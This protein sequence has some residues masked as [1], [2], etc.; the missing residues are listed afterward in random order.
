MNSN[1]AILTTVLNWELYQKSSQLFP[2]NIQKYIIDGTN[3][4]YGLDS[5]IYM[6]KMLKGR[7]ID[8]LIMADEDVLF[9][10]TQGIFS[11]I[12]EMKL[13][14]Y[15]ISGVRDGGIIKNR[16]KNPYVINTFFSIINFKELELIWNEREVLKNNYILPDEFDDDINNLK[17][18]YD[19]TSLY[20]LYYCFYLWLRR[21]EK[22]FFFLDATTPFC[23][24]GLTTA[25]KDEKGEIFLYHTWY[26]RAYGKSYIH[27]ER[28]N[29]IFELLKFENKIIPKPIVFKQKTF[30]IQRSARKLFKRVQMRIEIILNQNHNN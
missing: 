24:D 12:E 22:R 15:M 2:Q 28:I 9:I 16:H 25:V 23:E 27:T 26:A 3:G 4:M 14:N 20:E 10:N 21:K 29:K 8:W 6:M 7:N 17:G 19:T 13:N 11:I 1:I 30:F 18:N 5:I